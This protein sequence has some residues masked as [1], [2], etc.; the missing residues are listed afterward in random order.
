MKQYFQRAAE[1]DL[2]E[3][4]AYLEINDGWPSRQVEVY[5]EVWRWGDAE[6]REWL[7]DQPFSELGLEAEHAMPPEAFERLWQEAL[8]RWP[9][10][11]CAN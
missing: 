2:G 5:G 9:A 8:R 10:A 7:A 3:G 6:H 11:M 4:M 1:S